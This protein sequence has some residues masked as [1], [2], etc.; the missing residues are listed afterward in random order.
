[1]SNKEIAI[2]LIKELPDYQVEEVIYF[3]HKLSKLK[4]SEK[5]KS[6]ELNIENDIKEEILAFLSAN[7]DKWYRVGDI[8]RGCP[9]LLNTYNPSK[10]RNVI[11]EMVKVD[12]TVLRDVQAKMTSYTISP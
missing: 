8:M 12:N 5:W 1:M 6:R 7:P 11:T 3:L 9:N 10:V 4:S 2:K